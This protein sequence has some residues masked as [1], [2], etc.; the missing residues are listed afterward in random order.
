MGIAYFLAGCLINFILFVV[1]PHLFPT[2][3]AGHANLGT[4][5]EAKDISDIGPNGIELKR[6]FWTSQRIVILSQM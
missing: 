1:R 3:T 2:F 6:G 5:L 4:I